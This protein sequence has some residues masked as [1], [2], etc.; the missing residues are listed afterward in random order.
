M[1]TGLDDKVTPREDHS[2]IGVR[3]KHAH[4]RPDTVRIESIVL[5]E[6]LDEST[7]REPQAFVPVTHQPSIT[8]IDNKTNA[9]VFH[10]SYGLDGVVG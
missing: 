8:R 10:G 2:K 9:R 1:T 6:K 5:E 3:R 4:H 7:L